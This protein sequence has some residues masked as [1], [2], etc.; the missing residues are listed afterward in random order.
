MHSSNSCGQLE[1][2][3][4]VF[5]HLCMHSKNILAYVFKCNF[6]RTYPG[7]ILHF[8]VL[9]TVIVSTMKALKENTSK[10]SIY[11]VLHDKSL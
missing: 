4:I 10:I 11:E 3:L 5:T 7:E 6:E 2:F 9:L 1:A 8:K